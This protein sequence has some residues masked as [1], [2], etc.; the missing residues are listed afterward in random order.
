VRLHGEVGDVAFSIQEHDLAYE[1]LVKAYLQ[2]EQDHEA[3]LRLCS[4]ALH[5]RRIAL[6]E[7]IVTSLLGAADVPEDILDKARK[8][9]ELISRDREDRG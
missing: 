5:G 8:F 4:S 7:M 6:A 3:A 2:D 1:H 9:K